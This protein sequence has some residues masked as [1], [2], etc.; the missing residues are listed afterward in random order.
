MRNLCAAQRNEELVV[1]RAARK[2][3]AVSFQLS[4]FARHEIAA[5]C[6]EYG[7]IVIQ[8]EPSKLSVSTAP[9]LD[10]GQASAC[11]S[12]CSLTAPSLFSVLSA[13]SVVNYELR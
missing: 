2:L 11:P 10:E 12:Q 8:R 3:S 5:A 13:A 9:D 1:Q 7:G 4:A 6:K